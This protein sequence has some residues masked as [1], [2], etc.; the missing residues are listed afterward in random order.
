M[1][2][3]KKFQQADFQLVYPLNS[4]TSM[5]KKGAELFICKLVN[6][7][8]K[9]QKELVDEMDQ[10][11]IRLSKAG[12]YIPEGYW[13]EKQA[14][15][16]VYKKFK[17]SM[18]D[19]IKQH[20]RQGVYIPMNKMQTYVNEFTNWVDKIHK[21]K[22]GENQRYFHGRIKPSNLF[23]DEESECVITD[24]YQFSNENSELYLPPESL[25]ALKKNQSQRFASGSS[26]VDLLGGDPVK[27]DIWQLGLTFLQM[28]SL[29]DIEELIIFRDSNTQDSAKAIEIKETIKKLYG[30][31]LYNVIERMLERNPSTRSPIHELEDTIQDFFSDNVIQHDENLLQPN[32]ELLLDELK[33]RVTQQK[34]QTVVQYLSKYQMQPVSRK[35]KAT[36]FWDALEDIKIS[37]SFKEK[38]VLLQTYDLQKTDEID[39][40]SWIQR[41]KEVVKLGELS[42]AQDQELFEML[43]D[44]NT[45][46]EDSNINLIEILKASDSEQLGI[47]PYD[48]FDSIIR[49]EGI[50]LNPEDIPLLKLKYDPNK[51]NTIYYESFCDDIKS[52]NQQQL[53]VDDLK[54]KMYKAIRDVY[55]V[56]IS[57][58]RHYDS[59]SKGYLGYDDIYKFFNEIKYQPNP[60]ILKQ[61]LFNLDPDNKKM[62]TFDNVRTF[63][64]ANVNE[65]LKDILTQL[66]NGLLSIQMTLPQLIRSSTKSSSIISQS[67]FFNALKQ[68][69][70]HLR[71]TDFQFLLNNFGVKE[72]IEYPRFVQVIAQKAR[73]LHVQNWKQLQE[74]DGGDSIQERKS[75][76]DDPELSLQKSI[77]F[78]P[79]SFDSQKKLL[80]FISK[81]LQ[82]RD[83]TPRQYFKCTFQ[84]MSIQQF[85]DKLRQLQVH[86]ADFEV[87]QEEL[88]NN[89]LVPNDRTFVDIDLLIEAIL[90]Y[91]DK[92]ND[93]IR[94]SQH[95]AVVFFEQL[96]KM[97]K[98]KKINYT[99]IEDLD[100]LGDGTLKKKH[101]QDYLVKQL[102]IDSEDENFKDFLICIQQDQ[103]NISLIKLRQGLKLDE[104]ANKLLQDLNTELAYEQSKPE[105]L[106]RKYDANRNTKLEMR[107]F[108]EFLQQLVGNVDQKILE[109]LF[110][111]FDSNNDNT[112]NLNEFKQKIINQNDENPK[113]NQQQNKPKQ[114]QQQYQ[115]P[116]QQFRRTSAVDSK[117]LTPQIMKSVF[118]LKDAL[119]ENNQTLQ[120][121][122]KRGRGEILINAFQ[123]II[124]HF[125]FDYAEFR[126]LA[127]YLQSPD[128]KKFLQYDKLQLLLDDCVEAEQLLLSLN[129]TIS[130]GKNATAQLFY[131]YDQNGNDVLD[132]QE[133]N[134][135][136]HD[137]DP[138]IKNKQIDNLFLLL[139]SN[140]DGSI[141]ISE[142]KSKVF[143]KEKPKVLSQD[144]KQQSGGMFNE[145]IK[146]IK[147]STT[148][149]GD[150]EG[151]DENYTNKLDVDSI[152][153]VLKKNNGPTPQSL[154][155]KGIADQLGALQ[156]NQIN[157]KMLC[158]KAK[159]HHIDT[160]QNKIDAILSKLRE[161]LQQKYI[162][163]IDIAQEFDL[164]KK[165]KVK[166]KGLKL[167]IADKSIQLTDNDWDLLLT[168]LEQ[169]AQDYIDY[170]ALNDLINLGLAK[171]KESRKVIVINTNQEID[172]IVISFSQYMEKET[173]TLLY[174]YRQTDRDRDNYISNEEFTDLLLRTIGYSSS[175]D[176]QKQLFE[177]FDM[178]KDGKINFT[179]FEYQ[180][181]KR[182]ELTKQQIED[183]KLVMLNGRNPQ[184]E[185]Q[186][187]EL[188]NIISQGSQS[189]D[190]KQF[191]MYMNYYKKYK[192]LELDQ[193]FRYFDKEYAERLDQ[194]R[195]ILSFKQQ[196][197]RITP[198]YE[199]PPQQQPYPPAPIGYQQQPN[200][201]YQQQLPNQQYQQQQSYQQSQQLQQQQYQ[202][203]QQQP[204]QYQQ[205]QP[206]QYQQ[207]QQNQY[208]QQ[209][210]PQQQQSY[211]NQG[212]QQQPQYMQQQ[213]MQFKNQNDL[214]NP[215][216]GSF[217]PSNISQSIVYPPQ[218]TNYNQQNNLGD[219]EIKQQWVQNTN[220]VDQ[221]WSQ[222]Q[223][224]QMFPP[225]QG[226]DQ[227]KENNDRQQEN[228][229]SIIPQEYD[230]SFYDQELHRKCI[231]KNVDLFDLLCQYDET[232]LPELK[233]SRPEQLEQAFLF[234]EVMAPTPHI[235]QFY[236]YYSQGQNQMS[237]VLPYLKMNN[238]G[239][240]LAK[241]LNFTMVKHQQYTRQQ[242]WSLIGEQQQ[243]WQ[244]PQLIKINKNLKIGLN[245]R[246]LR[247]AFQ[248]WDTQQSGV[249]TYR[250]YDEILNLNQIIVPTKNNNVLQQQSQ[251][252]EVGLKQTLDTFL[253]HLSE[254]VLSKNCFNLFEQL[255]KK[256][257]NQIPYND[258]LQISKKL[259]GTISGEEIKA[260]KQILQLN[261]FINLSDL[262]QSLKVDRSKSG[263]FNQDDEKQQFGLAN[264]DQRKSILNTQ[265]KEKFTK[266]LPII[267]EFLK[268]RNKSYDDFALYFFPPNS[269]STID[270]N[271]FVKKALEAQFGLTAIQCEDLYDYLDA[272]SSG[273]ISINEFRLVFQSKQGDHN[274]NK[275]EQIIMSQDIEQ[276]IQELFNQIDENKNQ[277]LDQRELLKALQSVGLNPGTEE[278]T[279]YFA[280]FDRDKSGTISY[281]E[282]SH[283]VKDILKKELLQADDLLEDL[284][285]E[286]RQVCNPTTRMLSKEQ[287]S[288]VFQ[289]MGVQIKNE[290][291]EDL[292]IEIDE[293][294]SG[295]IDIDEFIYFIQ[296][297]QSG[298]SAKASA[299]VMN[300]K[301]SRRI[302]LH[303]LKEIF[304]TLPQNFIMSFVRSQNK[305]LQNLPSQQLKPVLDNCGFFY[306]GLNYVDAAN[307][308]IKQSILDK[309][310]IK[311]NYIAEIRM[312][313]ATGIPIPDEKDVPR[314][315]FLRREIG[316][317][318]MDK[319]LNKFDGNAIYIPAQWNSEYEDRWIFDSAAMEQAMYLRW[320][321]FDEKMDNMIELIF[322][323]ITYSTNKGRL[324]QISCAYG[325]IPV[326]Q[327]KPGKQLLELKGGAPLKDITID[328]KDIRTNRSG[329]RSVVKALSSNIKSQLVVEVVKLTPQTIFKLSA[330]PN[331]CLLNK[332][333]LGMQSAFRE[334]FAYRTQMKG[335]IELNL[336]SDI[337]IKAW[338]NCFDCP[339]TTRAVA[340]FWNEF[341]EPK[342]NDHQFLLKAVSKMADSLYLMFKNTEFKF[343]AGD[344]TARID[345]DLALLKKRQQLIADAILD[346][347]TNLGI[348]NQ[349]Q[350]KQQAVVSL[351][352]LN[353]EEMMD[354]ENDQDLQ[355]I[356]R[357]LNKKKPKKQAQQQ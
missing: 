300:I 94:F 146:F 295:S 71:Q 284:R 341:I 316:I 279:Q 156:G 352:P 10:M 210:N 253:L 128:D 93:Q 60:E 165:G 168:I 160:P 239:K 96:N 298:M 354:L 201:Q 2:Q 256:G 64:E 72:E 16:F 68:S 120:I 29:K 235:Q 104:A 286:F 176:V 138:S 250:M 136:I 42:Q 43:K 114:Q 267:N 271:I 82:E 276:E 192:I 87:E 280:Q 349:Q 315:S 95:N 9:T 167:G 247:E 8:K 204:N 224:Q 177:I 40:S 278:L 74:A 319:A 268:K 270:K 324:I 213:Q 353:I 281:Q 246:E 310:N 191:T 335:E 164:N 225:K 13:E 282:F 340:Q 348:G 196:Q 345:H 200:Q 322:E 32:P 14:V 311:N 186:I 162:S 34:Q 287:V 178:D 17:F 334:Y 321:N 5:Q 154:E 3:L 157:Y 121:F 80:Q 222:A 331:K 197:T 285:R 45:Y 76:F 243:T 317:I 241:A 337:R 149:L 37:I 112:I 251:Q 66:V 18:A 217:N 31:H 140:G 333:A 258:F 277:S 297:N 132:R 193:F 53:G 49:Q 85:K 183:M 240:L 237:I 119:N 342:V 188:F 116:Q 202:S 318:L 209:Q 126:S 293:D 208:Q 47:L 52:T 264:K 234:L 326:Y 344:P 113:Q 228:Q 328:K 184:F 261:G 215:M 106:F 122:D 174:L 207:Q 145:V 65:D 152:L 350:K 107:E 226:P 23:E 61:V 255:D 86:K 257:Y 141:S 296:K 78:N 4:K 182:N 91:K 219:N 357:F 269:A 294:K 33:Q 142:F 312:I 214:Q 238:P 25:A 175:Q 306:Q 187:S 41:Q 117:V 1:S 336:A 30:Q 347:K 131:N 83:E 236:Y 124:N 58:F 55:N 111:K 308:N 274:K 62:I 220:K 355:A 88:I 205:Q 110:H 259:L 50:N 70:D 273:N 194:F 351:E 100:S 127:S 309:V 292:F 305:K 54:K 223:D 143:A 144:N 148:V 254:V 27:V 320:G 327:L 180:V 26:V 11:K 150:F 6:P 56:F 189:I 185:Q 59:K 332:W 130:A 67:Q 346:M 38:A 98:K 115:E 92:R 21:S 230:L 139:D 199:Q 275:A 51:K 118:R 69:N 288:Q 63:F 272:N 163:V 103:Q 291:L 109:T 206:N 339:D 211:G 147:S 252:M 179:E 173:C 171:Y 301:G 299:A 304:L 125:G 166:L 216:L 266:M 158:Q 129:Q 137:I 12:I 161:Q 36:N 265:N 329:W 89:L 330:L 218:N 97:M 195:F 203:Q 302:S 7:Q 134:K 263:Q 101:L 262:A 242:L 20:K 46:L 84:R 323:F 232:A 135:L 307:F 105:Q 155:M 181:Y 99:D 221:R 283:I 231:Q 24:F 170:Y 79:K 248:Y 133:F 75:N 229:Q 28:A 325:S 169:D 212:Y 123:D 57:F 151:M 153:S 35:I 22:K 15:C 44:I 172:K 314:S 19:L 356:E 313:E 289:N 102:L 244:M 48:K 249:I 233:I 227:W 73:E 90:Y 108:Q 39:L 303:D 245:E 81:E 159:Q 290:E 343:S 338:L 77:N 260:I 198:Q 190:F